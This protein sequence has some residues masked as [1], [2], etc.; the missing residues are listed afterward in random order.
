MDTPETTKIV[1]LTHKDKE[2]VLPSSA[3][4]SSD[5]LYAMIESPM[6]EGQT[7][8]ISLPD[9]DSEFAVKFYVQLAMLWV[10]DTELT[11][12]SSHIARDTDR[13][14]FSMCVL[15]IE[16]LRE[17]L[18]FFDKY[19]I[20]HKCFSRILQENP[21]NLFPIESDTDTLQKITLLAQH[22]PSV[23][24]HENILDWILQQGNLSKKV[25]K[26]PETIC[27]Q[28][29]IRAAKRYKFK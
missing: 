7:K 19:Q 11:Q 16:E 1:I 2:Y 25:D 27:S 3:L 20:K 29:F 6:K 28:A 15:K 26:L 22:F 17:I 14:Y 5:V 8:R 21:N 4:K 13:T 24:L 12:V 10:N 23:K 18:D 9:E